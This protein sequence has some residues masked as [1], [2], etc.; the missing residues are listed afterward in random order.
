MREYLT[1]LRL[2]FYLIRRRLVLLGIVCL[3]VALLGQATAASLTDAFSENGRGLERLRIAFAGSGAEDAASLAAQM[4]DV[5]S[6]CTF[7][8]MEEGAARAA[9]TDGK[10]SAVLLLPEDFLS[11]I[12][13]GENITPTLLLDERRPLEG[14]L[15]RWAGE[16]AIG[17]L[18]DAQAGVQ[19]VLS[20]YDARSAAGFPPAESRKEVSQ[21][22]NLRYI[23]QALNRGGLY[24]TR[25]VSPTG[26]LAPGDHYALSALAYLGLLAGG[27]FFPLFD[28]RPRR[29]FLRRLESAGRPLFPLR[30]AALSVCAVLCGLLLAASLAALAGFGLPLPGLLAGAVFIAGLGGVCATACGH[31]STSALALFLIATVSLFTGGGLLPPALLP[32]PVQALMPLSP[33]RLLALAFSPAC[34]YDAPAYAAPALAVAGV[35]LWGIS[36]ALSARRQKKE[37]V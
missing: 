11:S 6:Y 7:E 25:T 9:L 2:S 20:A 31:A 36:L 30:L 3:L 4:A 32:A 19:A 23:Q 17:V 35:A 8:A 33:L 14:Y 26:S 27:I 1:G 37:A 13:S 29:G 15:A 34:G 24:R 16:N 10:I 21:G 18:M 12:Y 28:E 5:R 22:I